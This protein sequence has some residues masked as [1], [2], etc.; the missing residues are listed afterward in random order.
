MPARANRDLLGHRV[1]LYA[2]L[3]PIFAGRRVLEVGCGSG[4]GAEYLLGH[5]AAR[6][7]AVDTNPATIEQ[8]RVRLRRPGL[9]LRLVSSLGEP[10]PV[11]EVFDL[12]IVPEAEALIRRPGVVN[13][14]KRVLVEGG[15]LVVSVASADRARG[16]EPHA[17]GEGVGYYEIADALAAHF[18]RVRM[19]GQTPFLGFGVVEYE[20]APQELRVDSRL[21]DGGAEPASRYLGV[22][23]TDEV[24]GLGYAL[25]QM[26][27]APFESA[28]GGEGATGGARP[29]SGIDAQTTHDRRL[30]ESERRLR[31][32]LEE[33][34]GRA[35]ELRRRADDA[36]A[37]S[38]S[39]L[40]VTRAQGEEIEEL[41][42]RLR[43][44]AEDRAALDG[45]IAK[46][47][48]ALADADELVLGLTR[49]TA[50]EMAAMAQRLRAPAEPQP[51]RS[52][53]AE[54]AALRDDADR[55]RATLAE[56]EARAAAAEQRLEAVAAVERE[57]KEET[58]DLRARLRRAEEIA[59]REKKELAA[60]QDK[61]RAAD[62]EAR[63]LEE[64]E[65]ALSARD[66]RIAALEGEKQDLIWRTA[67][68]EENLRAAIA[69]V[70]SGEGARGQSE[71]LAAARSARDR[72][73]EEFHRAAG[74]H[75]DELTRLQTSVAEQTALVNEL[76]EALKAA[77]AKAA[78]AGNE[79]ASLR[80]GAKE[81]EE[82]DRTR[83]SRLAELEGKLLRLEHE[84]RAAAEATGQGSDPVVE[85][86]L[87]ETARERDGLR[88]EVEALRRRAEDDR[89]AIAGAR[90]E[91][92]QAH[93]RASYIEGEIAR[94]SLERQRADAA[95]AVVIEPPANAN[96]GRSSPPADDARIADG[97]RGMEADVR[98][99]LR[100]LAAIESALQ[101]EIAARS[102]A[103]SAVEGEGASAYPVNGG[104]V[105]DA[106]L[107]DQ[108]AEVILLHTT[109]ASFRRRAAKLRD[110]TEG[111]RRRLQSLSAAEISGFL[112]E[113]GDDLAE[114][115]K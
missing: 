51:S 26:P 48:R 66:A 54:Y 15:R 87:Q 103:R 88:V 109:L 46:L 12:V 11:G 75:V 43:R 113:L 93:A 17:I 76:E 64:R 107:A 97:L 68:L 21:V 1:P 112:E 85:R 33:T 30:E 6:V 37:Q 105:L 73:L 110:E 36:T 45:E 3:E 111:L 40:R 65:E 35:A 7:V 94:L 80:K 2:Y 115:E 53:L 52:Q 74:A 44:A 72:A 61:L 4:A 71:E 25:V 38:D 78:A 83:R 50:E 5:G 14:W 77:E 29:P 98:A 49:K 101:A 102:S 23:G 96:N 31:A 69:R 70:V 55:L 39:A 22:G 62:A 32:R 90:S 57:H 60:L 16:G 19:F 89:T 10:P 56:T 13:A 92:E 108:N 99:E 84:R 9:D 106:G 81:L 104:P 63:Q 114:F 42:G 47:R 67:E 59:A 79:A 20:G 86:K 24:L 58:D 91:A 82:A 8:A 100:A 27:F 41:R 18:P 95:A 34:E 28:L